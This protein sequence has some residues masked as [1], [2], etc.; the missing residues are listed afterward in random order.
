[1]YPTPKKF[2]LTVML[3][4]AGETVV[5]SDH[6]PGKYEKSASQYICFFHWLVI[7]M[8]NSRRNCDIKKGNFNWM[9]LRYVHLS[10]RFNF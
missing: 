10:Y 3:Y 5:S 9:L 7:K 8:A 2:H 1:M 4:L 6:V